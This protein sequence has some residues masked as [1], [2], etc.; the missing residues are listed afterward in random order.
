MI[1]VGK[2]LDLSYLDFIRNKTY[3]KVQRKVEVQILDEDPGNLQ[4]ILVFGR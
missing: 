2:N 3:E 4:G 1:L